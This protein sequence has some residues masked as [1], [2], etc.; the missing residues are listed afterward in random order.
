M[1][2]VWLSEQTAI[3]S[4]TIII[5]WLVL[6]EETPSISVSEQL[7]FKVAHSYP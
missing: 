5:N 4:L 7:T 1:Y 6:P 2:S 3:I